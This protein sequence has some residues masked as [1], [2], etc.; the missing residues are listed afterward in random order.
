ML[1]TGAAGGIGTRLAH[2]LSRDDRIVG[3]DRTGRQA[4]TPLLDV[5]LAEQASIEA[6]LRDFVDHWGPRI[7]SG[8]RAAAES[9]VREEHGH[10]PAV[11][12]LA[13]VDCPRVLR[14]S[15]AVGSREGRA[16]SRALPWN[17]ADA[18]SAT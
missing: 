5:D 18:H 7:A 4:D 3:M 15:S 8:P 11:A 12:L 1:V 14:Y 10:T 6:A 13:Q 9:V 2:A 16:A 17:T